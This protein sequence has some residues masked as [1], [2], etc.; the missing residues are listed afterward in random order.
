MLTILG[1]D[2]GLRRCGWAE[3]DLT[4]A[5]AR[6]GCVR[7]AAVKGAV[8]DEQRR[9][10]E[11][12]RVLR[13][14]VANASRVVVEWPSSGG[15]APG[16]KGE[17]CPACGQGKGGNAKS[18]GQTGKVAALVYGLA[19]AF[20]RPYTLPSPATWRSALGAVRGADDVIHATLRIRHAAALK[21]WKISAGDAPHVLDA[22][23]LAEYRLVLASRAKNRESRQLSLTERR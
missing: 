11:V 23:G 21:R 7:T 20:G 16:S 5:V 8:G 14:I 17:P 6:C 4:G 10:D 3:L 19:A 13:D 1:V 12:T 15:F 9:L 18:A 22:I 2:P